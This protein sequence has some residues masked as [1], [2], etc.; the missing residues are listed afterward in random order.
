MAVFGS[1]AGV[2]VGMRMTTLIRLVISLLSMMVCFAVPM[3]RMIE[4][5]TVLLRFVLPMLH[6]VTIP[7]LL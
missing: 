4:R 6:V 7:M 5:L 2:P 1:M 3:L